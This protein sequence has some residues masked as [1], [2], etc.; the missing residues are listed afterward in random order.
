MML[1]EFSVENY[2]S[3]KERQ[4]LSM[5]ASNK[6]SG[7]NSNSFP[8]P[9]VKSLRLLTSAVVYQNFLKCESLVSLDRG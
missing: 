3:F 6:K 2:R 7:R 1:V 5:V 9:N 8:M 4:T